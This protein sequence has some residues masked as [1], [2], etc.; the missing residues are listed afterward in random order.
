[1][2]EKLEVAELGIQGDSEILQLLERRPDIELL[3][4][5][6]DELLVDQDKKDLSIYLVLN[7][8]FK[9]EGKDKTQAP[10]AIVSC[11]PKA[12]VF[13]GEMA[14]F[15]DG[16]RT[17]SVRS[18][19]ATRTLRLTPEHLDIII[20]DFPFLTRHICRQFVT[21]L[22]ETNKELSLL[23]KQLSME[24]TQRFLGQGEVIFTKGEPA[25]TLC[26]LV[27]GKVV[28]E[29]AQG[30][31]TLRPEDLFRGFLEP[32]PYLRGGKR[33]S[34]IRAEGSAVVVSIAR[35]SLAAVLRNFPQLAMQEL[36]AP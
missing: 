25:D 9:V 21:R 3:R 22:R 17:A 18:A 19:G 36:T 27:D 30:L 34:T 5:H 6:D 32:G 20:E 2:P 35:A 16:V 14:Y 1:M 29:D 15:G 31:Q 23:R 33:I 28:R 13:V 26:Q 4:F 10:I 11:T 7:G 24:M 8:A 12:P